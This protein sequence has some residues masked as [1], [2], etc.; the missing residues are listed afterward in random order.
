M[1]IP[2]EMF[3]ALG[4]EIRRRS[5]LRYTYVVGLANGTIGYIGD[6]ASHELGGYQ[7]W[8]GFHSPSAP[9]TGE[10]MVEQ[11]LEMLRE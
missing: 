1:G 2:G 11:A 3:A 8:A 5:P 6:R 7:L 4:M 10:A 9:G